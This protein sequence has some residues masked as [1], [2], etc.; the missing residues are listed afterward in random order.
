MS[1][2]M[3]K[4]SDIKDRL[5][6]FS[7]YLRARHAATLLGCSPRTMGRNKY[8]GMAYGSVWYVKWS[9]VLTAL[10]PDAVGTLHLPNS[11]FSALDKARGFAQS[12][13]TPDEIIEVTYSNEPS[14]LERANSAIEKAK[15]AIAK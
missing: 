1:S 8:D 14:L 6:A 7:G 2:L 4:T 5:L 13:Q 9:A 10:G 12:T 11:A 15:Q 3:S